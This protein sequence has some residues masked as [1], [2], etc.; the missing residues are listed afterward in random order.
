MYI[1]VRVASYLFFCVIFCTSLFVL[2]SFSLTIVLSVLLRFTPSDYPFVS[3]KSSFSFDHCI[4]CHSSIY[5]FWLPLCI[6]K[7][8]FFFWPLYCMSFCDLHLLITPLYHPNLLFLLAIALY[9]LLRFTPSDYPFV[10]SKSSFSFGHCIVCNS[11]IYTFWLPLWYL[12]FGH[13]IVCQSL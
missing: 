7:I 8:I 13:C 6:I 11:S 4:L 1:V 5:T 9:V 12:S 3:S 10:S 2:W